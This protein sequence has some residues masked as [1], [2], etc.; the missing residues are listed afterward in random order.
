MNLISNLFDKTG[1]GVEV[2]RLLQK[3]VINKA[4]CL[5]WA[6][7]GEFPEYFRELLDSIHD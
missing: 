7:A 4:L 2:C 1:K 5:A 6:N 3:E